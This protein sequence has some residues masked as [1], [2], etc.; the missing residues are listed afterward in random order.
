MTNSIFKTKEQYLTFRAAWASA[1]ND[2]KSQSFLKPADEY[3]SATGNISKG[4][5]VH[6][7]KGW[8]TGAHHILYNILRG[9]SYDKGFTPITNANK[10]K[11]G[12][13]IN[14]GL[15]NAMYYLENV[16][17]SATQIV[18]G[19]TLSDWRAN[20]L[21]KFIEPF[22]NTVTIEMLADLDL[23]EVKALY[24]TFGKSKKVADKIITGDFKPKNFKQVYDALSATM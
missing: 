22:G 14:E 11:H 4:T 6:R 20:E 5:G 2:V 16:W 21:T 24:S 8:L 17:T 10:L 3:I 23:P 12:M 1:V 9:R 18:N 7:N 19:N 15:Y 13:H